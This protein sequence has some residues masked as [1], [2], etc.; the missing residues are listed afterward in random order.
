MHATSHRRPQQAATDLLDAVLDLLVPTGCAGCAAPHTQLCGDCRGLLRATSPFRVETGSRPGA[1]RGLPEVYAVAPYADPVRQL[2]LAHKER[3][4][5]RLARPLGEALASAVRTAV[6]AR[7]APDAPPLL[8][9]PV[10]SARTAVR[11]RGHDPMRRL[12][13]E[14]ARA[15]RAGAVPARVLPALRLTRAVADQAGLRAEQ[16]RRNL[17]GALDVAPR[18]EAALERGRVVLVDDLITTG[19]TLSEATRALA[20][21]GADVLAIAAICA[22]SRR[23][24]RA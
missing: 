13:R 5:V 12:T 20:A 15:L 18:W 4:A 23:R 10:P 19:S 1:G 3:G 11:S 8:L 22:T 9:V 17:S 14:A 16:R 7:P 2:I 6:R 21:S 24:R